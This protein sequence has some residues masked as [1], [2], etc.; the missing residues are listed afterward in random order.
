MN[1]HSLPANLLFFFCLALTP[2]LVAQVVWT[3][4]TFP[5]VDDEVVLYFNSSLGNGELAGVIPV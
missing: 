2:D 3:E 5:S 4:P 1:L